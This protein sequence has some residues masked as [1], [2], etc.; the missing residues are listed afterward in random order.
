M[1]DQI[2][3][4]VKRNAD[5]LVEIAAWV[6]GYQHLGTSPRQCADK[7]LELMIREGYVRK[8]PNR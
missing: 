6:I 5:T 2:N 3:N 4:T 7:I 8:W 1:T